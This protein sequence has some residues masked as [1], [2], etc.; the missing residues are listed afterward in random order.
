MELISVPT[1]ITGSRHSVGVYF[2]EQNPP[3]WIQLFQE[4]KVD[5]VA[6]QDRASALSGGCE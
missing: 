4:V 2:I 3:G 6:G 5:N 1:P